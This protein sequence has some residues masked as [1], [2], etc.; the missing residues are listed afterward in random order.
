MINRATSR[1]T[2]RLDPVEEGLRSLTLTALENSNRFAEF[3]SGAEEYFDRFRI[4]KR[5]EELEC[6]RRNLQIFAANC[7]WLQQ[8]AKDLETMLN[9]AASRPIKR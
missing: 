4:S 8:K 2:D 7:E 3:Q 5:E 9:R 1:P 6:V